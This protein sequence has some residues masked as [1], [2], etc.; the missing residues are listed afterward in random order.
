MTTS[1]ELV[2]RV[3]SN[4][5]E[6]AGATGELSRTDEEIGQWLADS[7][8]DYIS[9][10]P[11]DAFPELLVETPVLSFP[12]AL[13]DDFEKLVEVVVIHTVSSTSV[14]EPAYVL[15]SDESYLRLRH[16][17]GL[18]AWAQIREIGGTVSIDAGPS[19]TGGF[20]KY[21]KVPV[22]LKPPSAQLSLDIEHEEPIVN[23]ATA[24]ALT[25]VNDEDSQFYM[26]L[27]DDRITAEQKKY[28][29]EGG[30]VR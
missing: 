24:L 23:R 20:V 12:W 26:K 9:K 1:A 29:P 27:Y 5:Y 4:I 25:K 19:A 18:G 16:T 6:T 7:C 28:L 3:R 30:L 8:Y 13:P 14:T 15:K 22:N 10:L 17:D 11:S 2:T 21:V